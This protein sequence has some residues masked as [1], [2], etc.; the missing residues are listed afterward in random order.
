MNLSLVKGVS[1]H[2]LLEIADIMNVPIWELYGL[3]EKLV[4]AK[5]IEKV[6]E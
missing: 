3:T 4:E 6:D 2:S 5:L 1:I